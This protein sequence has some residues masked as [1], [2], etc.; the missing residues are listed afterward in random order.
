[1]G[2]GEAW[3]VKAATMGMGEAWAVKAGT[4]AR[5]AAIRLDALLDQCNKRSF[6][7]HQSNLRVRC[8]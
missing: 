6:G 4:A 1:M 5:T 7:G 2:M 8:N 3:A